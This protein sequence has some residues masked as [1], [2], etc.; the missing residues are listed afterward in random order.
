[1]KIR[2]LIVFI[3]GCFAASAQQD[4]NYTQY[5]NNELVIN[6]AYA[7]S[8]KLLTVGMLFRKQWMNIE[9]APS[10]FSF[11]IHQQLNN[12]KVGVGFTYVNDKIGVTNS[13][14]FNGVAS[15][16]IPISDKMKFQFGLN[17]GGT[18]YNADYASVNVRDA[19]DTHFDGVT[20][21]K[22]APNMG[23]GG[24][25]FTEKFYIGL[26]APRFLSNKLTNEGAD[27]MEETIHAFLT[28]GYVFT[29]SDQFKLK[30]TTFVKYVK[31]APLSADVGLSVIYVDRYW[32][33]V[34]YRSGE[35]VDF[36]VMAQLD[37]ALRIGYSYDLILNDL[38]EFT[39][40]SHEIMLQYV[41][42]YEKSKTMSPRLF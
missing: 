21:S 7:G 11:N 4:P 10:V 41:F 35:S 13:H 42:K 24:Y 25:L 17:L 2:I 18:Y 1:M 38:N 34:A 16:Q 33:G 20:T 27:L 30:P 15:Y 12:E 23:A 14:A 39:S 31:A 3:L 5:F 29:V 22:F 8:N 26:S 9:K 6:P 36:S 40:G 28:A 37:L 32:L 19:G